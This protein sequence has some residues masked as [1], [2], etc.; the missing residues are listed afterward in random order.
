MSSADL[1]PTKEPTF[2]LSSLYIYQTDSCNLCCSH[3][4]IA[5]KFSQSKQND[6]P[7]DSLKRT[8][9]EAKPLGLQSVKITGGEP[10]LYSELPSFLS[11]L[12]AEGLTVY[13]ETNG[14]LM[15]RDII[16]HFRSSNVQQ[17][18]VSVDAA[19]EKIHD[20]IRGVKG[21]LNRT[22]EGLRLLSKAGVSSQIM[23]T[24][25]RK[26]SEE[27]EGVIR[28]SEELGVSSLKINHLIP[29]GRGKKAFL[30]GDNLEIEELVRLYH[31]VEEKGPRTQG[32]EIIFDLPLAF[33]PIKAIKRSGTR[34]CRILNILG[35]LA[36]GDFSICGIGQTVPE[37][38]LGNIN[39]DSVRS[40][41]QNNP[42][43][44]DLR[45]SLPAKLEGICHDCIFK[46]QCLGACR[47]NAYALTGDFYAPYFLCQRL[48]DA[49]QFPSSRRISPGRKV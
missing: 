4:W 15:D 7:L 37:L 16:K 49:D 48:F 42:I 47:A 35:I 2:E 25:Q 17:V 34:E 20:E 23:M 21:S 32:L 1:M 3:C 24:L 44:N 28:L 29:T 30:R 22:L 31:I 11:F 38:R 10:L 43:L 36:N 6:L 39:C 9:T 33:R 14:T 19:S 12:D 8:V 45:Q 18:S 46:F 5:P 26:N 41:W 40:V 27:V 13:I